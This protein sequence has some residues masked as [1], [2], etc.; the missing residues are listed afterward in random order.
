MRRTRVLAALAAC[1]LAGAA[2]IAAD[3]NMGSWKLNEAKSKISAGAPKNTMV[4]YEMAGDN[5]KVTVTGVD[6]DGKP[7]KNEWTGK[8]DGKDYAL[9]G[10]PANDMRAYT[11]VDDHTLTLTQK[12]DGKVTTT[13]KIVVSADGKTRTVTTSGTNAKGEKISTTAV[14]DKQ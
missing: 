14:Y 7:A 1:F 9:K 6:G 4:V 13:G 12:K 8:F 11:R 5:I 10:D 2:V 3:A